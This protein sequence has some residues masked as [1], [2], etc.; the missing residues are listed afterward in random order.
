MEKSDDNTV[1]IGGNEVVVGGW[2]AYE[3]EKRKKRWKYNPD[4]KYTQLFL[5]HD[6]YKNRTYIGGQDALESL[7]NSQENDPLKKSAD[8]LAEALEL[9]MNQIPTDFTEVYEVIN[10]T[11][12]EILQTKY[13]TD[14]NELHR[15][16]EKI[17]SNIPDIPDIPALPSKKVYLSDKAHHRRNSRISLNKDIIQLEKETIP[18]AKVVEEY[19]GKIAAL[20]DIYADKLKPSSS[21]SQ[22]NI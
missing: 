16:A 11:P 21:L 3:A 18:R 22:R 6:T 7:I 2:S 5:T 4:S 13:E 1:F 17:S 9:S 12:E 8:K 19:R 20:F 15:I 14:I 10:V